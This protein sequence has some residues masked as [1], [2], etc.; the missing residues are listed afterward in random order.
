MSVTDA[1]M[2]AIGL[3]SSCEAAA[4]NDCRMS[5]VRLYSSASRSSC[6]SRSACTTSATSSANVRTTRVSAAVSGERSPTK[7]NEPTRAG[8]TRNGNAVAEV[9]AGSPSSRTEARTNP[10]RSAARPSAG[11]RPSARS[12]TSTWLRSNSSR[13]SASRSSAAVARSCATPTSHEINSDIAMN[14]KKATTYSVRSRSKVPYGGRNP[15]LYSADPTIAATMPGTTPPSHDAT[16]TG[17]RNA[18]AVRVCDSC[19]RK[20]S[21]TAAIARGPSVATR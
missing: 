13:T 17:T 10:R 7:T 5:S 18:N 21:I 19:T 11:V 2:A 16:T 6:S 15:T 1:V 12:D 14:A 8:P 4:S 9:A 3:F 20:G